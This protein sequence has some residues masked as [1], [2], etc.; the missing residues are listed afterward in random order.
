[1]SKKDGG[2]N[3][4]NSHKIT[5]ISSSSSSSFNGSMTLQ[6]MEWKNEHKQVMVCLTFLVRSSELLSA[7]TVASRCGNHETLTQLT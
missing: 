7:T 6:Q 5:T 4:S 1:M 2:K 3:I